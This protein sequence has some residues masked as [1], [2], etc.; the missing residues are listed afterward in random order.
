[1]S[2]SSAHSHDDAAGLQFTGQER[3][4][5]LDFWTTGREHWVSEGEREEEECHSLFFPVSLGSDM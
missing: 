1:M 2:R 3:S 5:S 4:G